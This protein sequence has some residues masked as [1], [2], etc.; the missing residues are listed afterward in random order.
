M[1]MSLWMLIIV[2]IAIFQASDHFPWNL[3][4]FHDFPMTGKPVAI[5]PGAVGTMFFIDRLTGSPF[6]TWPK[7]YLSLII[8]AMCIS[9]LS[10]KSLLIHGRQPSGKQSCSI[11]CSWLETLKSSSVGSVNDQIQHLLSS[12]CCLR[13]HTFHDEGCW[14]IPVWHVC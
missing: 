4:K 6:V 5:F 13:A 14:K 7:K 11:S 8:S 1:S 12:F 10:G 3:T 9:V 2:H